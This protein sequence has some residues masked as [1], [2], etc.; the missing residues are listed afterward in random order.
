MS[1]QIDLMTL[2]SDKDMVCF[3]SSDWRLQ[4][5]TQ[6]M[7]GYPPT[8]QG[9]G[10][11][12][13]G[14]GNQ[15]PPPYSSGGG[16]NPPY[17]SSTSSSPYPRRLRLHRT[18]RLLLRRTRLLRQVTTSRQR[19][20]LTAVT[21]QL[22]RRMTLP[23]T[24]LRH[25]PVTDLRRS[26]DLQITAVTVLRLHVRRSLVT[27]LLR[28]KGSLNTVVTELFHRLV[29]RL[30]GTVEYTEDILLLRDLMEAPLLL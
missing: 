24:P 12:Y 21:E 4:E 28:R 23:V 8:S 11:S 14:G 25:V 10:Y 13:G 15:P 26:T 7:S 19:R 3:W 5:A 9:Y 17:G 20:S 1:W 29:R 16:S 6:E 30:Q 27:E 2:D 18:R 22:H